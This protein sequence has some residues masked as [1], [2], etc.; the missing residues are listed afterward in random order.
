M[1]FRRRG[2]DVIQ[3]CTQPRICLYTM[4]ARPGHTAPDR[5][6]AGHTRPSRDRLTIPDRAAPYRAQSW[7]ACVDRAATAN[8]YP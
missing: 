3:G 7:L 6:E 8:V 5:A 1:P 4:T 2:E